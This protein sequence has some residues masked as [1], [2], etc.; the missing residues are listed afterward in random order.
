[1]NASF[2]PFPAGE[3]KLYRDCSKS[4]AT[5]SPK[6]K[7]STWLRSGQHLFIAH[8]TL[9][10]S[11]RIINASLDCWLGGIRNIS[12]TQSSSM[13]TLQP[14]TSAENQASAGSTNTLLEDLIELIEKRGATLLEE[15]MKSN[16]NSETSTTEADQ[17]SAYNAKVEAKI[18]RI[19]GAHG[20]SFTPAGSSINDGNEENIATVEAKIS[21]IMA[22]HGYSFSASGSSI[23]GGNEENLTEFN[24][25]S[26]QI[27]RM[28]IEGTAARAR[29]SKRAEEREALRA[30]HKSRR[31]GRTLGESAPAGGQAFQELSANIR[32]MPR[33]RS[34]F[35][36]KRMNRI[37]HARSNIL[38]KLDIY[39]DGSAS[40]DGFGGC[41]IAFQDH[42]GAWKTESFPLME[43]RNCDHTEIHGILKA[44][45]RAFQIVGEA[46][47][48]PAVVTV[49]TDS[50]TAMDAIGKINRITAR[51]A[52]ER[53]VAE[54]ATEFERNKIELGIEWVKGHGNSIGNNLADHYAKEGTARS[55]AAR[56]TDKEILSLLSRKV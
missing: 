15:S 13:Q 55:K 5:P 19:M 25:T 43:V 50:T 38:T 40:T 28:S 14:C 6:R 29:I 48:K 30:A 21:M 52:T 4:K 42:S 46:S 54:I 11:I 37:S 51:T 10:G 3:P 18:S 49:L 1:M 45:E 36:R 26:L 33:H 39:C 22:A 31:S 8:R 7:H 35:P 41:G 27:P 47:I 56:L 23:N 34:T 20:Y 32:R 2:L 17:F 44:L 12:E 24:E 9:W 16:D 53:R